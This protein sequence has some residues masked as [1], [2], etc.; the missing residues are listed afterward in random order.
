EVVE[1]PIHGLAPVAMV[2]SPL[3]GY[4]TKW[5]NSSPL[6]SGG[7]ESKLRNCLSQTNF[8]YFAQRKPIVVARSSGSLKSRVST[9]LISDG[10]PTVLGGASSQPEPRTPRYRP[11]SGPCGFFFG[12]NA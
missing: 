12:M 9:V 4:E 8:P 6:L 7:G 1:T 11:V 10:P 5:P 3:R 2:V